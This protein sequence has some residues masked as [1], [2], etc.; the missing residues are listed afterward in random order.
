MASYNTS[1]TPWRYQPSHLSS[2]DHCQP[3][4]VLRLAAVPYLFTCSQ[5]DAEATELD[6]CTGVGDTA[7]GELASYCESTAIIS[8]L[9]KSNNLEKERSKDV[10]KRR[11]NYKN[12]AIIGMLKQD[13][14]ASGG[15][16]QQDEVFTSEDTENDELP[17]TKTKR[18]ATVQDKLMD[19][20][21]YMAK[22]LANSQDQEEPFTV[23]WHTKTRVTRGNIRKQD[24]LLIAGAA[25]SKQRSQV[26][27]DT[28]E[29]NKQS[30]HSQ[31]CDDA[32]DDENDLDNNMNS[33]SEDLDDP[34]S[35][36]EESSSEGTFNR[37][38][39][40]KSGTSSE[41]TDMSMK[42]NTK[43]VPEEI[44][45]FISRSE[46]LRIAHT[47]AGLLIV[48]NPAFYVDEEKRD[49]DFYGSL[50]MRPVFVIIDESSVNIIVLG[51]VFEEAD[52]SDTTTSIDILKKVENKFIQNQ[53][54]YCPGVSE[55]YVK[56]CR[57]V[58]IKVP[59]KAFDKNSF[60]G[61]TSYHD[62][63]C[64]KFYRKSNSVSMS[65]VHGFAYTCRCCNHK[66]YY[67]RA[68]YRKKNLRLF[69]V[70]V[71][72]S[73][74]SSTMHKVV[75]AKYS[76]DILTYGRRRNNY[77][78]YILRDVD[79]IKLSENMK[80]RSFTLNSKQNKDFVEVLMALKNDSAIHEIF[81]EDDQ[82]ASNARK[83]AARM[84]WDGE[85]KKASC[86]YK[87]L[88]H[89]SGKE[90]DCS[91]LLSDST[92][93]TAKETCLQYENEAINCWS[94]VTF[95]I[96][97][98]LYQRSTESY[99]SLESFRI[100]ELP[101]LFPIND[102]DLEIENK[103][104]LH[105]EYI[106][107]QAKQYYEISDEH[108]ASGRLP[109]LGEGVIIID[110]MKVISKVVW[111]GIQESL[112]GHDLSEEELL[113]LTDIFTKPAE[114][115][116]PR[117]DECVLQTVWRDVCYNHDIIGPYFHLSRNLK[118]QQ[119]ANHLL[120]TIKSFD[121]FRLKTI[122]IV[123]DTAAVNGACLRSSLGERGSLSADTD[124]NYQ[125]H[126]T[127][128]NPFDPSLQISWI[129][130]PNH[131]LINMMNALHSS[132]PDGTKDFKYGGISFGWKPLELL[133]ENDIGRMEKNE[134]RIAPLLRKSYIERR[135]AVK[136]K[137][138][139]LPSRILQKPEVVDAL[140]KEIKQ[141]TNE[142][143]KMVMQ[144]TWEFLNATSKIFE[145]GLLSNV[146]VTSER[147]EAITNTM[148]G[149]Q[150]F[151]DWLNDMNATAALHLK[152]PRQKEFLSWQ[153]WEGLRL[154]LYGFRSLCKNF[155][156]RHPD[157]AIVP[158][159]VN[160]SAVERVFSQVKNYCGTG[161][162]K[163]KVSALNYTIGLTT[164]K[165]NSQLRQKQ[166]RDEQAK[167]FSKKVKMS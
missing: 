38:P 10:S 12:E 138:A 100:L 78:Y 36:G 149:Y 91:Y 47:S 70:N 148:E 81:K 146:G 52:I 71:H 69:S 26:S 17:N 132:Q 18:K 136:F 93:A 66:I 54:I 82:E 88:P 133:L 6:D 57:A 126:P 28:E 152:D 121:D 63:L 1:I 23:K 61:K 40:E 97:L 11:I 32:S 120:W 130:C 86:L 89:S 115:I 155:H 95:R 3:R 60:G 90:E 59:V 122:G 15:V 33:D 53:Y 62:K 67:Y 83:R 166:K 34:D 31:K 127:F 111:Y 48:V 50:I 46:R 144:K 4:K 99:E 140:E 27:T 73:L 101:S 142:K 29:I 58:G 131:M 30:P 20:T 77:T 141:I 16:L 167:T 72:K 94:M 9:N 103:P 147:Q 87:Q 75:F 104:V 162:R 125:L 157:R 129:I 109:C 7:H 39:I 84:V 118:G 128:L 22:A 156:S 8:E 55:T 35:L 14:E 92:S 145:K 68:R 76:H 137:Y 85:V 13:W 19:G 45:N 112:V 113:N 116:T 158:L 41:G 150:W 5:S 102:Y 49:L 161:K 151:C 139:L 119:L 165:F 153:T 44:I 65:R 154:S 42:N 25:S 51:K 160:G 134:S 106:A 114:V 164:V 108:E 123:C 80:E 64:E 98:A 124:D 159:R 107:K 79:V 21:Q 135:H 24:D 163:L 37:I 117:P 110:Q 105:L 56:A 96:A 43:W 143:S 2:H 74:P